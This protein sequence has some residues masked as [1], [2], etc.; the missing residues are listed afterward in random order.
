MHHHLG[1][2]AV[3]LIG[4]V[5][6]LHHVLAVEPTHLEGIAVAQSAITEVGQ[7]DVVS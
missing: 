4:H 6:P 3:D 1:A 7:E 2:V 5:H